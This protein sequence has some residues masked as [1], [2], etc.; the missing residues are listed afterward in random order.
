MTWFAS[1]SDGVYCGYDDPAYARKV[2]HAFVT[3]ADGRTVTFRDR[4]GHVRLVVREDG[5][6]W[7]PTVSRASRKISSLTPA[8]RIDMASF[9]RSLGLSAVP[10]EALSASAPTRIGRDG[11]VQQQ[12]SV[13]VSGRGFVRT[14]AG[15]LDDLAEGRTAMA[16]AFLRAGGQLVASR[17][18]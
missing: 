4:A 15:M 17:V 3:A 9:R 1:F 12:A 2:A 7:T 18:G 5:S 11:S 13:S 10:R 14:T 16:D 6:E 8:P